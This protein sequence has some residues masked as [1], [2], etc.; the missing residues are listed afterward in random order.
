[1]GEIYQKI[2]KFEVNYKCTECESAH[3]ECID[4]PTGCKGGKFLHQCPNCKH[5][6]RLETVYPRNLEKIST[7]Q[8]SPEW[9]RSS[10]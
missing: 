5:T 4:N 10:R 9:I 8:T 6:V 2:Y 7:L 3:V 1:M